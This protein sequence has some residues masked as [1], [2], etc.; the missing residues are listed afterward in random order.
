MTASVHTADPLSQVAPGLVRW[1]WE[2]Y[3]PRGKLAIL[4]G[5]PGV[6]KSLISI[7]LAARLSRGGPLPDG[8]ACDRPHTTLLLSGE[9]GAADT[10]RPRAE[11]A[12]ADL[13]RV[14]A[15]TAADGALM[16]F[17]ADAGHLE[18]LICTRSADLVVIDPVMAFLPAEVASNSDQCVRGV[19]CILA[20]VAARTDCAILLIRHLRKKGAA[21]A[22]HR[23]LGS[24]GIIGAVRAGLLLAT[25]PAKPE[26]RVLAVTKSNLASTPPALGLRIRGDSAASVGIEWTGAIEVSADALAL[27]VA[28]PLR[29]RDRAGDWLVQ[30][31]AGGPRRVADLLAAAVK[32]G[33]PEITLRRAKEELQ[34]ESVAAHAAGVTGVQE[35]FWYDPGAPW[36]ANAPF[37]KPRTV[38][39]ILGPL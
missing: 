24:I 30:Q 37:K 14:L 12:G 25:N 5:D 18:S 32:A 9:D 35:W 34:I 31:L 19:L 27:P 13:D 28:G 16:R 6:G 3:L 17:P 7:D 33:I 15:V 1:L 36:P 8:A 10:L 38:L 2:P 11:A 21:K 29:P 26:S 23:G 22:V 39:D 20:G 4:D